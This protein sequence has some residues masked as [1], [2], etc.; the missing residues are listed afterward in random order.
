MLLLALSACKKDNVDNDVLQ[1]LADKINVVPLKIYASDAVLSFIVVDNVPNAQYKLQFKKTTDTGWKDVVYLDRNNIPITDLSKKTSYDVRVAMT[2][3]GTTRF[4]K[5]VV[6]NTKSFS[7][8]YAQFFNIPNNWHD[9][10]AQIFSIEGAHHI[11]H[12]QG[13]SNESSINVLLTGVDNANDQINLAAQIINDTMISFDIPR[14]CISNSPYQLYKTYNCTIGGQALIG[15]NAFLNGNR[16]LLGEMKII[17]RDIVISGF[18]TEPLL[19]CKKMT[20]SGYFASH[21]T[22]SVCPTTAYGVSLWVFD[23][24]L[25]IR[26]AGNVAKEILIHPTGALLCDAD[27]LAI[28]DPILLS[29]VMMNYH[30]VNSIQ[31]RSTL[32]PGSYTVQMVQTCKDGTVLSSNEYPITF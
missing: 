17:N 24:K 21:D 3:Y 1:H 2:Q 23:R 7:I 8:D 15:Y 18:S 9:N 26:A 28:P 32:S 19:T 25:I 27:G 11:I 20:L 29:S 22:A 13:F 5:T 10:G 14:N 30:E 16:D 6:F 31:F 4:S 12:G